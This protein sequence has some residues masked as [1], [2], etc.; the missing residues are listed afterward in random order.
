MNYRNAKAAYGGKESLSEDFHE[1]YVEFVAGNPRYGR[2]SPPHMIMLKDLPKERYRNSDVE[3]YTS[4]F[5]FPTPDPYIGPMLSGLLLDFDDAENPERARREAAVVVNEIMRRYRVSEES[6]GICFSGGKGF[7]LAFSRHIFKVQSGAFLPQVWKSMATELKEQCRL[8]TL[9]LSIYDCRRLWRLP[10]SK[11][12]SG[13]YKI[14]ITKSELEN[15]S[16]EKIRDLAT[17]PRTTVATAPKH[18]PEAEQWYK[19][20]A[21]KVNSQ[22]TERKEAFKTLDLITLTTEPP[23]VQKLFQQGAPEGKR[24]ISRYALTVYFRTAGKSLDEC[25][26]LILDFNDRCSPPERPEE[27]ARQVEYLYEREY[28]VGCG[29]FQ[30]HCPGK[31]ECALFAK[32]KITEFPEDIKEEAL[33]HLES[34]DLEQWTLSVYDNLIVRETGNKLLCH[35]LELSGR[36][37]NPREKQ[38]VLLMGDP[39]AGK[40]AIANETTRFHKTKKRGRL[41]ERALDYGDLSGFQ[42]L[43]LQ[44]IVGVE[45]EEHGISTLRFLSAEDKGYTVEVVVRDPKTGRYTTEEFVIPSICVVST[46]ISVEVEPQL[47]R[48]AWL[49]NVDQ[50][51]EQTR[52]VL[53]HK[54]KKER[55]RFLELMGQKQP[56]KD[57]EILECAI[58]MLGDGEVVVPYPLTLTDALDTSMLRSRGDYDKLMTLIKLRVWYHQRQRQQ[59][60]T[61][62]GQKVWIATPEDGIKSLQLAA[63][64]MRRWKTQLDER[65][66]S[67]LPYVMELVDEPAHVSKDESEVVYGVTASMLAKKMRISDPT[68]RKYLRTMSE[69]GVLTCIQPRGQLKVYQL[70]G[71]EREIEKK[72]E[73]SS[74]SVNNGGLRVKFEKEAE[75]FLKEYRSKRN[76]GTEGIESGKPGTT[77]PESFGSDTTE[78]P[79]T[80][81]KNEKQTETTL[82][83]TKAV[84]PEDPLEA[85]YQRIKPAEPCDL[86]GRHPVEYMI[87]MSDETLLERCPACFKGLQASFPRMKFTKVS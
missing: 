31:A 19:Q 78:K 74:L 6:I 79:E 13:Y 1:W 9:D 20:H 86:C 67:A 15:L 61:P 34:P 84:F 22:I 36:R 25:R 2:K 65:L 5:R 76:A 66:I 69:R 56:N 32:G 18:S 26:A 52:L 8:K 7:H 29:A 11:H 35:Y 55:E 43:Y 45:K 44:E 81:S 71:S 40:T 30:E 54:A 59:M 14:H 83:Q 46:L 51:E 33:R 39:G 4:I 50:S 24:N 3:A 63:K 82:I 70:M 16:I 75:E 27:A 77:I 57:L 80:A 41:S 42:I 85:L 64:A 58:D 60:T 28:H 87:Y 21:E 23:C 49:L 47:E 37:K 62:E 53:E 68:A 12:A 72:L 10:N 17:K 38:I 48:R 73:L